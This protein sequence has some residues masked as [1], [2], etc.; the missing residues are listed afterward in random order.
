MTEILHQPVLLALLLLGLQAAVLVAVL[1]R[2][3]APPPD[4]THR[5]H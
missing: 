3:L 4:L 5:T 2:A 1:H